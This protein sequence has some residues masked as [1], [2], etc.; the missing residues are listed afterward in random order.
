MLLVLA[1]FALDLAVFFLVDS[2]WVLAAWFLLGLFPKACISAW[3]H[4]HQHVFT[5][6][7]PVLNRLLEL[8]YAFQ[9][10]M[11]S[12]TWL[13]HHVLGHHVNYRDQSKDE[14]RWQRRDGRTMGPVAYGLS[15]A[16]TAYPRAFRVGQRYPRHLPMF[17]GMGALTLALL[18]LAA[19]FRPLNAL[20]VFA[21]P[22]AASLYLTCLATHR[23]HTGLE[24]GSEYESS[25]N[26]VH[27]LY[28]AVLGNLG[29]HTAHH[30]RQGLHWSRLP[31]YH[32]TIADRI[33]SGLYLEPGLPWAL[34][35]IGRLDR[36]Q[37]APSGSAEKTP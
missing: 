22:M 37:P 24:S 3:N 9:T 16:L 25:Y 33:P 32:K 30:V 17:L 15:V 4:H 5:F 12:H 6:S 7:R 20:F 23:H 2:V 36:A 27:P 8:V 31:A 21:L 14:S 29:Y 35:D 1:Y 18:G 34:I 13:L 11:T 10:G 26:I 28:N 19:W